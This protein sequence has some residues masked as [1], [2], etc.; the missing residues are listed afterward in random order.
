M[1]R[2]EIVLHCPSGT[3][4]VHAGENATCA[5]AIARTAPTARDRSPDPAPTA[6]SLGPDPYTVADSAMRRGDLP[7]ARAALTALIAADPDGTDAATALLDLARLEA[8]TDPRAALRHL[9]ALD[10]HPRHALLARP[11]HHLRCTLA[12]IDPRCAE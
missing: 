1:L 6:P 8:P 4:E 12:P 9:D 5:A 7:A 3:R 2:G 10:A 11:A